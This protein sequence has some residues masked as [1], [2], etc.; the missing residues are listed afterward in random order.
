[1]DASGDGRP[2]A[3][4]PHRYVDEAAALRAIERLEVYGAVVV[5]DGG[6]VSVLTA[7]AG[8]RRSPRPLAQLAQAV[9]AAAPGAG[10]PAAGPAVRDVVPAPSDDPRG[11][12]LGAGVLPL[13]IGGITAAVGLT[14]R[15]TGF[16]PRLVGGLALPLPAP[17]PD[18]DP[19]VWLGSLDGNY[20]AN[21]AVVAL[22]IAAIAVTLSSAWS[23]CSATSGSASAPP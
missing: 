8:G 13:V 14:V 19:A 4:D 20:W 1:V 9:S 18:R 10:V 3:F 11:A 7:S 17:D 6:R 23:P 2:G 15:V 12:G 21:S 16:T 5:G 22:V